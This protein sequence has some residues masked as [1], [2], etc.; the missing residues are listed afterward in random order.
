MSAPDSGA[1]EP[2]FGLR[3]ARG[4]MEWALPCLGPG[5]REELLRSLGRVAESAYHDCGI[6]PPRW[7][8]E[9]RAE[10]PAM[11]G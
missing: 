5:D 6:T 7:L 4:W 8:V 2:D 10:W 11:R 3:A 1:A 9:L